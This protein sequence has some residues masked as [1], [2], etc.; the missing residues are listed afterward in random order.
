[1]SDSLSLCNRILTRDKVE[2]PRL[3]D[4]IQNSKKKV[5]DEKPEDIIARM[6]NKADNIRGS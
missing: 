4:L 6:K 5:S 1:M 3:Y 2:I